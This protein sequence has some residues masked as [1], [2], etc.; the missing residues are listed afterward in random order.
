MPGIQVA[1]IRNVALLSH[2]GV[3]KTSLSEALLFNH[4]ATT[5]I[6]RVEDGNTVSDYEPEEIKRNS[7][8]Q[9][10]L[11][12]CAANDYKVNF[13]DTPGYD[14]FLGEVGAALRVV[15]GAVILVA[16][17]SG[18]DVGTERSW[19]MCEAQGLPRIILVNK[20]DRENASFAR[21]V[22]DIQGTFGNHCVPFQIPIGDAQDFTG[23]VSVVNPPADVPASVAD[24]VQAA[25]ERLIEAAAE[26]D[27]ALADKYL[28]GEE[29]TG[30]EIL[31]GVRAAIWRGELIPIL[32]GS[33]TKNIGVEE[34]L[35][36]VRDFLPSPVDGIRPL[37]ANDG[38][39]VEPDS[40]G[41]LAAFVFKTTADPFVGK[42]SLFRVYRGGIKSNSEVW[43]SVR[44]VSERIG[45]LYLPKGKSQDNVT[46]VTAGDI[47][48]I[49]KLSET[50]TGDTLCQ[51]DHAVTFQP[52]KFPVGYYTV[53]VSPATKADLDK[54]SVALSR[55]VEEDPSLEFSRDYDTGESLITGVGDAQIEVAMDKI[56]RKFGADLR[57]KMPRVAYKETISQVT[58]AEY[59][60]KKQSGGHG[61]YGHVILRLEPLERTQG[62]EFKSEVV[63][64]KV[65]REYFPSVEK[66]VIKAMGEGVLAGYPIVDLKAVLYDGS[67]HDVDS[68]GMSFEIAG[69]Q[70]LRK[71]VADASPI[72]LEP[73]MKLTVNAPDAYTGEV[74]SDLNTKRA[75]ILG[76]TPQDGYTEIIAEV[77]KSEVQR[78]SQDLR[79]VSQGRGNYQLE[80]DHYEPVPPNLEP[81]VIE[82]AKR[83]REEEKV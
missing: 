47:G 24:E 73:I 60:H 54:M 44:E 83:A 62:F 45:Q 38:A 59:R 32:A 1:N 78:Y 17:P 75:R 3:G 70:A 28:G 14:D 51:R 61:Q 10:T 67:F 20:M 68:S 26:S 66:G 76:M 63:G 39:D 65:P 40:D 19:S 36:M 81:R 72:L 4:K 74:M 37:M 18:V 34:C 77:P 71:G 41:P 58:K 2:S 8:V 48:A 79:S 55:I 56:R 43:N 21:C 6:G 35:T 7:S 50:L 11:I 23:V 80:F 9:T 13:L 31:S 16:A 57:V 29:L 82:E 25:R 22:S 33:A 46:E 12:A 30:E 69:N 27:E 42:L 53:A 5:R 49:G 64:G 52:V 15:E